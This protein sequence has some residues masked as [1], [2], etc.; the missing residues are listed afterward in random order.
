MSESLSSSSSSSSLRACLSR[1]LW[2]EVLR[3]STCKRRA[4][5]DE[6]RPAHVGSMHPHQAPAEHWPAGNCGLKTPPGTS[7]LAAKHCALDE[8]PGPTTRPGGKQQHTQRR[9]IA[10]MGGNSRLQHTT[11]KHPPPAW[12]ARSEPPQCAAPGQ[13]TVPSA[14]RCLQLPWRRPWWRRSARRAWP[15]A[16]TEQH[17]V[18]REGPGRAQEGDLAVIRWVWRQKRQACWH[19]GGRGGTA[20]QVG[21]RMAAGSWQLA[22]SRGAHHA[23]LHFVALIGRGGNVA[24][25]VAA[26]AGCGLRAGARKGGGMH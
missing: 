7:R 19:G 17:V 18:G 10:C 25:Q 13:L 4:P 26:L 8:A 3:M 22:M 2:A 20:C 16:L 12:P 23:A 1:S 5:A 9:A 14:P 21:W 24:V 6:W 15:P 11:R